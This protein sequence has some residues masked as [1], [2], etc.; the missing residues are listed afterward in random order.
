MKNILKQ[1]VIWVI[2]FEA[3]LLLARQKP[4]IIAVTG[5]IGKTSVKDAIYEVVNRKFM[6]ERVRRVS[7]LK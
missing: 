6:L 3:R 2:T 1:C 7:I 4:T 5:N